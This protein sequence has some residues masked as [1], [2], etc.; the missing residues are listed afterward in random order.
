MTGRDRL[1]QNGQEVHALCDLSFPLV[2]NPSL[3]S[4][5]DVSSYTQV[6]HKLILSYPISESRSQLVNMQIIDLS[7]PLKNKAMEPEEPKIKYLN[8][9]KG[10]L[11]LGLAALIV[12]GSIMA[13][14]KNFFLYLLGIFRVIPSD[15]PEGIG[16][17]WEKIIAGT[18]AGTHLDAPYHF[19]PISEGKPART[20]DNLPLEWCFGNG[21]VLDMRHKKPGEVI[22]SIDVQNELERIDYHIQPFDIVLIMTGADK[23]WDRSDYLDCH[24]GM[25]REATL[26][27]IEQGVRVMGIDAYG[28]DRPFKN[29]IQD[30]LKTRDKSH[31]WPAHL[32]GRVSEYAHLERLANLDAIPVPYGFKVACFPMK[33]E[34]ASAGWTRAVAIVGEME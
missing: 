10:A 34:G 22:S 5:S 9:K 32:A 14:L 18:H 13:T 15:F 11:L 28:F 25:S 24:P 3:L 6:G 26:W 23:H 21:V 31:L 4:I 19:G 20:I 7:L 29:M 30:Y 2:G 8:H 12:K 1:S 33:I 17:A 16:L 27:L